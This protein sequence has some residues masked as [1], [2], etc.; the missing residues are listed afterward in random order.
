MS[1]RSGETGTTPGHCLL[2]SGSYSVR[3][4][5]S[6]SSVSRWRDIAVMRWREDPVVDPWGG[7][8]LLR[9]EDSGTTWSVNANRMP[10]GCLMTPWSGTA[11]AP[12][13]A[14]ATNLELRRLTLSNE[15]PWRSHPHAGADLL[16]GTRAGARS[17]IRTRFVVACIG[18]K[19]T[20]GR[21]GP[22]T[23]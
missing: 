15:Q 2:S 19:W 12:P 6:G 8:L 4:A 11:G 16:C 20:A 13:S 22:V 14:A 17:R 10:R 9:D 23:R 7:Y 3:L 1:S 21:W 5:A 18:S